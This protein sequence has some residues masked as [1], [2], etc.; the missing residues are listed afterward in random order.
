MNKELAFVTISSVRAFKKC[1]RLPWR[2]CKRLQPLISIKASK[3]APE[4]FF[5]AQKNKLSR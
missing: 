1:C 3:E 2:D 4:K 5:A